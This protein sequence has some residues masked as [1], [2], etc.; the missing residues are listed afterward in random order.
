MR[1]VL[2]LISLALVAQN[3]TAQ[4]PAQNVTTIAPTSLT[5]DE[6]YSLARRN[7]PVFQR[8]VNGRRLADANVRVARAFLLPSVSANLQGRYQQT[9][10][11][12]FNGIALES[13]GDLM[14]SSYGI[15]VN[16]SISSDILFGPRQA[17]AEREAA[18]ADVVGGAEALRAFV[19]Q[20]YILVLQSRARAEVQ[21]TLVATAKGQ[22][23]L[24]KARQ[25]VGGGTILEVRTAEVALGRAEVARLQAYNT[26]EVEMLRL[27]QTLG[28]AQPAGVQLT[29]KFEISQRQFPL[30][31][32]LQL[33][34]ATN[35]G[36]AALKQRE[37][38]A[39]LNVKANMGRY[40]PTLN[41][42]TGWGG[43]ASQYTNAD[44]LVSRAQAGRENNLSSC[45][46][47]DSLRTGA[48][49]PGLS[50]SAAFPPL[51]SSDEA[52]I[53]AGNDFKFDRAPRSFFASLS[54][55]IFNNLV[56]EQQLQTAQIARDNARFDL[57][58]RELT[59]VMEVTQAHRNLETALKTVELNAT[60]AALAR[61]QLAFAQ[62]RY[63][64]GAAM[65]L[66]VT[67]ARGVFEQAEIDRVNAIYEYHRAFSALENAVG[68]PLR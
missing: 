48:G 68:R 16:Y 29:T 31:S 30:D 19:T 65:F 12:F 3:V 23:D 62:E 33:A 39:G 53:R 13:Q 5:L 47:M 42:G 49:L 2:P 55:P 26:A 64:V 7:N 22:V 52:A 58:T 21:D 4:Q 8:A 60:N 40:A 36:I 27:F 45:L 61:E 59:T 35:P 54:V 20:Q 34:R 18:E 9:G 17:V 32:L 43:N 6:A 50:C 56:R 46:T 51:T 1:L 14:Q 10:Q 25:A 37:R 24:A 44:F 41:L 11:Q 28:V 57:R 67:N 66:D 15:N 63:R 38:A